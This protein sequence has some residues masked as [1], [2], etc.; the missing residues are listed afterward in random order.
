VQGTGTSDYG[1][2]LD[3]GAFSPA[4][5][6][7]HNL[8]GGYSTSYDIY[9]TT[10]TPSGNLAADPRLCEDDLALNL[11]SPGARFG[12]EWGEWLGARK[13]VSCASGATASDIDLQASD[14]IDD[15]LTVVSDL[16][17]STGNKLTVGPGVAFYVDDYDECNLGIGGGSNMNEIL[18]YGELRAEGTEAAPAAFRSVGGGVPGAWEGI[19]ALNGGGKVF[20]D[21]ARIQWA[22][23]GVR[24][25]DGGDTLKIDNCNILNCASACVSASNTT[26]S[27]DLIVNGGHL[28]CN[29]GWAGIYYLKPQSVQIN[30]VEIVGYST[31]MYGI[32][33]GEK[34]SGGTEATISNCVIN[35]FSE[36]TAIYVDASS[37]TL[38]SNWI[39]NC[40]WGTQLRGTG[41]PV[42]QRASPT[43][44]GSTLW[45]CTTGL[46]VHSTSC[47]VDSVFV[48]S[49]SGGI[50]VYNDATSAGQ[51]TKL[52][53]WYGGDGFKAFS[54]DSTCTLR[55]S[56]IR[57]FATR[58]VYYNHND[59]KGLDLG[60][61]GSHGNN[62]IHSTIADSLS[63]SK[64]I[65]V[66]TCVP[67]KPNV[68]AEYNYWGNSNPSSAEF[69]S[70][71]DYSHPLDGPPTTAF[72]TNAA[73]AAVP[74]VFELRVQPNP[75]GNGVSLSFPVTGTGK[76]AV[77]LRIFNVAGRLVKTLVAD[78]LKP[79]EYRMEWNGRDEAGLKTP[80]GIYFS[81]LQVGGK[82]KTKK[83]VRIY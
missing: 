61:S 20:L 79:G 39:G 44:I 54:D 26:A 25:I 1:I 37:P 65:G 22:D 40:K 66:K 53:I 32:F 58:G 76:T 48:H 83:L 29:S 11:T 41:T 57:E 5:E 46:Y 81:R 6:L 13:W 62:W 43:G 78:E 12:N 4:A 64:Y 35:G 72:G 28:T 31:S 45:N 50:G 18:V 34:N 10:S 80:P 27:V 60:T 74:V 49:P 7:T 24:G 71:V 82:V 9:G 23:Y 77:N 15:Q 73:V 47:S 30:G 51:Y 36:G 2:W 38:K 17:V 52:D 68:D 63:A 75:F 16:K 56:R 3:K 42:I 21:H 55:S 59:P 70:C 69:A 14:L 19:V 8:V 67:G 33:A